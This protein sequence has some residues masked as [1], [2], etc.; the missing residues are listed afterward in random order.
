MPVELSKLIKHYR[1]K[2]IGYRTAARKKDLGSQTELV[3]NLRASIWEDVAEDLD[4][5]LT[6]QEVD[7]D[8]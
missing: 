6:T 2:A 8:N 7:D 3:L 4:A 1:K 5:W